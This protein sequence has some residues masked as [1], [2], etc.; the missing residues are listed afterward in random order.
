MAKSKLC[1]GQK[2]LSTAANTT[3]TPSS[4]LQRHNA[5]TKVAAKYRLMLK[6]TPAELPEPDVQKV[7]AVMSSQASG[8]AAF[9]SNRA[10]FCS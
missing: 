9:I 5:N 3:L 6:R 8:T 1:P 10:R 2:Q 7:K 4:C